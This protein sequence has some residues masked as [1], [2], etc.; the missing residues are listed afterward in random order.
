MGRPFVEAATVRVVDVLP[1][2]ETS[3]FD[4]PLTYSVPDGLE[5]GIGD[6]VTVPLGPRTIYA[7]VVEEPYVTDEPPATVRTVISRAPSA[8]AFDAETLA[9]ARFVAE[10]YLCTLGE[11]LRAAILGTA[12]PRARVRYAIRAGLSAPHPAVPPRLAALLWGDLREGFS[13]EALLR[14]PEARRA[15][16]RATLTAALRVLVTRGDVIATSRLDGA[17][18]TEKRVRVLLPGSGAISGTRAR[19]L[20][21]AVH[22]AGTLR[23][24]DALLAGYSNAVIVRAVR[25]GAIREELHAAFAAHRHLRAVLPDLEPT[26]EQQAAIAAIRAAHDARQ[27]AQLLVHGV[28]GSGKTLVYLHAIAH[29]IEAGG[30]AIVLVPEIALTPQTARRFEAVFGERVAVLHSALSERERYDAWQRAA[31]GEIDVI[32]GARSAVFAPLANLRLIVIDEAHE[33]SYK[34]E[35]VPRYHAVTVARERMRRVGGVLVLGSATPPLDEYARARAGRAQLI[36]LAH[37][38]TTL[39]LP[40]MTVVDMRAELALGNR[41]IFSTAL[42]EKIAERLEA[43]EKTVLFLNRRGSA[44]FLLCRTCG[45]VAE[46]TRCTT[47]LVVH[48]AESLLRCHHCDLQR[49]LPERCPSCN[50]DTIREFGAGTQ[51]VVAELERLF[52]QARTIRMDS[53]TTTRIG[54]H[55]RLLDAFE[56][57]GDVLVGTQMVAKGLDFPDVTLVGIVAADVGLHLPDYR[58]AERT[59]DLIVQASGRSGRARPGETVVQTYLPEHPAIV[60]AVDGDFEGFARGELAERRALGYPPYRAMVHLGAIAREEVAARAAVERYAVVLRERDVAEVLG[61]SPYPIARQN[62]EWRYRIELKTRAREPLQ[63]A[64]RDEIVPLARADRSTRLVIN[65]D[66]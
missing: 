8:R 18:L 21:D 58:A 46:C 12:V 62:G 59:F 19:T 22:A 34:Q 50:S 23:R 4:R 63:R 33:S 44:S 61:P 5:L 29:A 26:S 38:A 6:V 28:T 3:R 27:F 30:R 1:R 56:R 51:R 47:S 40:H 11:A 24:A 15:G 52:P 41:R 55:A 36:V 35:T 17:K 39:P 48:R 25:T 37:R 66:P 60:R 64:I 16:D 65:V 31:R 54:D 57:D 53:D 42:V 49:P 43:H 20:V 10:Y 13:R 32:V 45:Y 9:L 7:Y 2:L 14:H